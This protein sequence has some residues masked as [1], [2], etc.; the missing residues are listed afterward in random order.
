M[1][2]IV[3]RLLVLLNPASECGSP[4]QEAD[5]IVEEHCGLY[6]VGGSS[7]L[8]FNSSTATLTVVCGS[9]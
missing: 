4:L 7:R 5:T 2:I 9:H 1:S 6:H 3:Y 8:Y